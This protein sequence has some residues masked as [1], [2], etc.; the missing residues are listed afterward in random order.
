[1]K[2]ITFLHLLLL[3]CC[4]AEVSDENGVKLHVFN[5][6]SE[7][8]LDKVWAKAGDLVENVRLEVSE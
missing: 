6:E 5:Y 2:L 3:K 8:L 1:M 7:S 4:L